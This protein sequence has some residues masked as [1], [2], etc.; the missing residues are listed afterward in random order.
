MPLPTWYNEKPSKKNKHHRKHYKSDRRSQ[1]QKKEP[2]PEVLPPQ[3]Q[4]QFLLGNEHHAE[5]GGPAL[6][7]NDSL[8]KLFTEL[9]ELHLVENGEPFW[10][11]TAR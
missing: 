2:E 1:K 9:V 6:E 10:K 4:V 8:P 11:E 7:P 3:Q 5:D